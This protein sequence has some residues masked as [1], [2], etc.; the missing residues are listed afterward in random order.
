MI[1]LTDQ[2]RLGHSSVLTILC[3]TLGVN[4]SELVDKVM[5]V[6]KQSDRLNI[7]R[8]FGNGGIFLIVSESLTHRG[9]IVYV[10]K[11][12]LNQIFYNNR[13]ILFFKGVAVAP[14]R[15]GLLQLETFPF[16]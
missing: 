2:F 8:F 13:K 6:P 11:I 1:S 15:F 14:F 12:E 16:R 4:Y 3:E 10:Y 9:D 7:E 5:P